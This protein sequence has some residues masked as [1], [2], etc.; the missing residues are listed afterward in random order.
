MS[1]EKITKRFLFYVLPLCLLLSYLLTT[2]YGAD[3]DDLEG[4][5]TTIE[6][7]VKALQDKVNAMRWVK[8]VTT[9]SGGFRIVFDDDSSFD[10]VNGRDGQ[11]GAKGED[12]TRWYID[13]MGRW[14]SFPV[15][16]K[17][18]VFYATGASP[19]VEDGHWVFYEWNAS[20]IQYDTIQSKYVADTTSSYIVDHGKYYELFIPKKE[21]ILDPEGTPIEET[22]WQMIKLPKYKEILDPLVFKFLGYAAV[23]NVNDTVRLIE[24]DFNL[25]WWYKDYI[26]DWNGNTITEESPQWK[27]K[28]RGAQDIKTDSFMIKELPANKKYAIVFSVNRPDIVTA[29]LKLIDSKGNRLEAVALESAKNFDDGL[30]TKTGSNNDSVYY[31]RVT[32]QSSFPGFGPLDRQKGKIYYRLVVS[33]TIKSELSPYPINLQQEYAGLQPASVSGVSATSAPAV[34]DTFKIAFDDKTTQ[35]AVLFNNS[36]SLFDHYIST[37]SIRI[38]IDSVSSSTVN[39]PQKFRL[40]STLTPPATY[41]F[42]IYVYMLHKD[43]TAKRDTVWV[44]AE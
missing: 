30:I 31:T 16:D 37:D 22:T 6:E 28:W 9:I 14:C 11:A 41:K 3:L 21:T 29:D 18:G 12:G 40:D 7:Q 5:V 32:T 20:M 2:C 33:D 8:S 1:T 34:Q 36:A 13:G 26:L 42:P 27:W 39:V 23:V 17:E 25:T 15:T 4:R 38:A 44:K 35:H 10:I 43:G 19:R 24:G